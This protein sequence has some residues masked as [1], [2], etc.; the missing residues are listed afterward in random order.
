MTDT[1]K[2]G[3]VGNVQAAAYTIGLNVLAIIFTFALSISVA[4]CVS[5]AILG[6]RFH[7]LTQAGHSQT[8][9]VAP[10]P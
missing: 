2:P 10:R 4:S 3:L 7:W 5:V 8:R 9:V 6:S 1:D